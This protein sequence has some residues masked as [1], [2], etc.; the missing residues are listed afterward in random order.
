MFDIGWSELMILG[1]I[2]LIVVGPK[3]LP[4]LLRT[5]GRYAGV[6]KRQAAEFRQHF[7]Q[8]LK[9]AELDKLKTDISGFRKEVEGAAREALRAAEKQ[10][11]SAGRAIETS[12]AAPAPGAPNPAAAGSAIETVPNEPGAAGEPSKT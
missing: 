4:G 9:E 11:E 1:V 2:A 6:A 3:E 7:D 12:T 8:A 10:A 5:I